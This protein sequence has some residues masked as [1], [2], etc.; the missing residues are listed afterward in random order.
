M[1]TSRPGGLGHVNSDYT[2]CGPRLAVEI[3]KS[4]LDKSD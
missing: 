4:L 2:G 3:I 1:L